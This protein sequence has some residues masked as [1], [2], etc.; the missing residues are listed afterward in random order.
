MARRLLWPLVLTLSAAGVLVGH[1]L[2]YRLAGAG[3]DGLHGYLVHAPQLLVALSLPALLVALSGGRTKAPPPWA[4]ALLG[5]GGFAAME[6]LERLDHG[7]V[8]WLLTSPLFLLGLALQLPFALVVWWVARI[9]LAV[10]LPASVR[11][12]RR[13]RLVFALHVAT[14]VPVPAGV[15][16]RPRSRGPPALL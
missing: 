9:L 15:R 8:P 10:E 6:H 12:R 11:P 13:P 4:F 16:A 1:E 2:A 5:T 7:G 3:S 14:A